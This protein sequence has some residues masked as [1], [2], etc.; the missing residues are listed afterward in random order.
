MTPCA[1][2]L[3]SGDSLNGGA[4]NDTYLFGSGDGNTTVSHY[5]TGTDRHDVL[6]FLEGIAAS[7]VT[8]SYSGTRN[9][10]RP[11]C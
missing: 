8:A 5:D 1:V 3:V 10:E 6:R 4:G 7:D 11:A 9:R 2:V